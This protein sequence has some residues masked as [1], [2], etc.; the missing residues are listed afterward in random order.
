MRFVA[1]AVNTQSGAACGYRPCHGVD[2]ALAGPASMWTVGHEPS[3]VACSPALGG[4]CEVVAVGTCLA[5]EAEL[6]EARDAAER[7]TWEHTA[8]LP[9]SYLTVVRTGNTVRVI[10]D[11]AGTM[12]VYWLRDRDQVLWSTSAAALAAYTHARPD[13]ATLLA[14]LT[15]HGI[16]HLGRS[17]YFA[18]VHRVPPGRALTLEPGRPPRTEAVAGRYA[19]LDLHD[20]AQ[21]LAHHLHTAVRRRTEQTAKVSADLSGGIDSSAL[22]TLAAAHTPVLAVTYTD[23]LLAEQDDLRYARRI[24][25]DTDA[26]THITVD[27]AAAGVGHFDGLQDPGLLPLTD[28][29]SLSLG[30]LAIKRAQLHPAIEH[31]ARIHLT[32]R[33]GDNVLDATPL[34]MVDLALTGG[35]RTAAHR[36]YAFARDRTAPVRSVFAQAARTARTTYPQ[37]LLALADTLTAPGHQHTAAHRQAPELLSWCGRLAPAWLTADGR[38]A[39]AKVV[40]RAAAEAAPDALPG[41]EHERIALQ[42]MGEEHATYDEIARQLW[43]LPMHAPY[44]DGPVIDACLAVPGWERWVPEDFKPLARTALTGAVPEHLL[45]RR[46][47]TPMTQSLHLGLRTNAAP[48]R[49]IIND[50]VVAGAGLLDPGPVL[51]ALDGAIRGERTPLGP[52]HQLITTELWL[53]TLP[54][55]R[56]QWWEPIPAQEKTP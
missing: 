7:G 17:S 11:R 31:G 10:G 45:K 33:G 24:A 8:H 5:T 36:L 16:D 43:G 30:L 20:G 55:R 25:A 50:S 37:A 4:T 21:E 44:L 29:P 18:G 51:A 13:T 49:R 1:G 28:S 3:Q 46:T 54:T 39:V 2:V 34:S 48:L 9:G 27:G 56:S 35:W 53:S 22:A 15:V 42:R 19:R 32:G 26:I 52:L 40:A 41:A 6:R 38:T 23:R 12:V 14:A 47:K